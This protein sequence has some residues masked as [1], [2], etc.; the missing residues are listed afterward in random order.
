[1][2][3]SIKTRL[4]YK[5]YFIVGFLKTTLL[6]FHKHSLHMVF[7]FGNPQTLTHKGGLSYSRYVTT[8][9]LI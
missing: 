6:H 1:M 4:I 8:A 7:P 2:V 9:C 3:L 5:D